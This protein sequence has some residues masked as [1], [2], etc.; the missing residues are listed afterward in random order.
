MLN[1]LSVAKNKDILQV[2]NRLV[3]QTAGWHGQATDEV[4]E[5]EF[6]LMQEEFDIVLLGAG[7]SPEEE[8]QLGNF[9]KHLTFQPRIVKHYGG[10]SGLLYSEVASALAA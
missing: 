7:L 4:N 2:I 6:L 3:N 5:A 1:I 8:A 10:G 9:C